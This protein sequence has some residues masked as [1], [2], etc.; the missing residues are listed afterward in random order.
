MTA[1]GGDTQDGSYDFPF[2]NLF[3]VLEKGYELTSKGT[4]S[5]IN[6]YLFKGTHY[7][8]ENGQKYTKTR[9]SDNSLDT[10]VTIQ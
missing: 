4:K 1:S 7:V 2:E 5:N 6:I 10:A 9:S 8:L 3:D